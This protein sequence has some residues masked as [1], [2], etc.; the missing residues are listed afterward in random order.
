MAQGALFVGWGEV[1]AG[2]RQKALKVFNEALDYYRRLKQ[3]GEIDSFEPVLLD[4]RGGDLAGYLLLKGD[5]DKLNRIKMS[6][7]FQ[8]IQARA[9]LIV[10]RLGV[11]DASSAK[12]SRAG[13][14]PS[15]NSW[16]SSTESERLA[17]ASREFA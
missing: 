16:P 4:Y 15:R 5:R 3:R 17:T 7:E 10:A 14:R 6:T 1:P 12:R 8:T 13:W 2:Y 11:V 9:S